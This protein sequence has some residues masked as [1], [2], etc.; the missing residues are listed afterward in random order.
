ML[1]P[2]FAA[3][4]KVP[5]TV[6]RR[7]QGY[8]DEGRWVE[9]VTE[10]VVIYANIQPLREHEII[11]MPEA[12][13]SKDWQKLYTAEPIYSEVEGEGGRDADEFYWDGMEDGK[14][15][16]YKVMKVRRYRMQILSHWKALCVRM[17]LTPN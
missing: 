7:A 11:Q 3:T 5:L 14:L 8:Y 1:K 4:K 13:R 17:E 16:R 12:E 15:Y 10:E 2:L 6:Y 9:G